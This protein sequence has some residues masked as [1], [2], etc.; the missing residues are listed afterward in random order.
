MLSQ[1]K[2]LGFNTVRLPFSVQAVRSTTTSGIDFGGGRNAALNGKTPLQAMDVI[3]QEAAAQ[4]LF[5][6]LDNHSLADDD[7]GYDLWYG[8]GYTEDDWVSTWQ[9][10]AQRYRAQPNVIAADLK[11]EPHGQATWGDGGPDRLAAGRRPAPAT[12]SWRSPRTG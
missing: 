3:V 11:N 9:M 7:F 8:N 1:I 5:V 12:P 4:G 6:M 2:S 10:M